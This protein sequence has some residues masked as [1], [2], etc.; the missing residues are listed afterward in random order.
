MN[1]FLAMEEI[2]PRHDVGE[3]EPGG[4]SVERAARLDE[5]VETPARYILEH[6]VKV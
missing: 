2:E 3:V 5:V 6:K 4:G 1:N